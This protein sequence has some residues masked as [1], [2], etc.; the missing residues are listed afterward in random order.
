MGVIMLCVIPVI[1]ILDR[2]FPVDFT[3]PDD[4][5]HI[6][7]AHPMHTNAPNIN[8][9]TGI[10]WIVKEAK[11]RHMAALIVMRGM[12]E[13]VLIY[14]FYWMVSN[15]AP[16]L[17]GR[18]VFFADF[19]IVLNA[20]TL[21]LLVFGANRIINRIGLIATLLILPFTLLLGT[22]YL[23]FQSIMVVTYI[24]R[25]ADAAL[26]QALYGQGLDRM[27]LQVDETRAQA[28]RPLFQGLIIRLG[29]S[30]A[31]VFLLIISFGLGFSFIQMTL[32]FVLLLVL[33]I[34]T[35]VSL[36]PYLRTA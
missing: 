2:L 22:S 27:L 5:P 17:D 16:A 8:F 15:Q 9:R 32:F 24:L 26:E 18:T 30:F 12:A 36:K 20:S 11:L 21:L 25:I 10:G 4:L 29:R 28:V 31:A 34:V 3:H 23:I 33:W 7:D 35:A 1:L 6:E 14:L 19:Y 13:T